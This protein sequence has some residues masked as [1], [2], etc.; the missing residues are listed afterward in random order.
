MRL[1]ELVSTSLALRAT[2]SRKEKTGRLAELLRAARP[3]E[4][5]IVVDYLRGTLPQGKIGLGYAAVRGALETPA[6]A[7]ASLEVGDV[8]R[9]LSAL[10]ELRGSGSARARANAC[11]ALFARADAEEQRFLGRLLTGELRQ[12]ASDGV[13]IEAIA[14]AAELPAD[15]VRRAWLVAGDLAEVADRA[16]GRGAAALAELRIAPLRPLQPML[17]QPAEDVDEAL[18]RLGRAAFDYKLDGARIQAHRAGDEVRVYS[19]RLNDVTAAVPEVVS[20]VRALPVRAAILDGEVVALR[21]DGR[22]HPFQTTMRRFGRR[23]DVN[24][25]RAELPLSCFFFDGLL[26]DDD[27]LTERPL[28]ERAEALAAVV[29]DELVIPRL[30]TGDAEHAEA[31]YA[32]ALAAGHEGLMA[33]SLEA[34][35]RLGQRG[36]SWLKLKTAHTLDLVVLAAEWGSGRRRGWLSNLHLGARDPASGGFV[37]LGKTFK[38]LTD[39]MLEWQTKHLEALATAREGHVVHVRPELVVEIAFNDVQA[40]PHYPAGMALRFARVKRH[41]PDKRAADADTLDQVRALFAG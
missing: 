14:G 32:Q 10:A 31:F 34:A 2:R 21:A 37:M 6:A 13:M 9:A 17:A 7:V 27:D 41:R 29:P 19:R 28:A 5:R 33:K 30:V 12:G 36:G 4:R 22:P 18:G 24:A 3:A 23:S 35:Y 15:A 8:D 38:G 1:R 40:S 16:L 26:V 25:L 11:E 39:A 20:A